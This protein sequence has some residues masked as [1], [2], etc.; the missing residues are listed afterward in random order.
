MISNSNYLEPS[1]SHPD[2]AGCWV[3]GIDDN[4]PWTYNE[5]TEEESCPH[6]GVL[7]SW[8][9]NNL[10]VLFCPIW[11]HTDEPDLDPEVDFPSYE[12]TEESLK[13][14]EQSEIEYLKSVGFM[15]EDGELTNSY[16]QTSDFWYDCNKK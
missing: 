10:N 9:E 1:Y 4:T 3:C 8:A 16:Y 2:F 11:D 15:N 14:S 6:C 13:Q 5:E 7:L 12:E